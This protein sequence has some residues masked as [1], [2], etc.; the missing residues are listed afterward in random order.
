MAKKE[1]FSR[2][3]ACQSERISFLQRFLPINRQVEWDIREESS[4]L[5][6]EIRRTG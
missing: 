5:D 3:D 1:T 6:K 2:L 4:W